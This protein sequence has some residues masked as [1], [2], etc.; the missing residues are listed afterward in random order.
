MWK[1]AIAA[2]KIIY[3]ELLFYVILNI[4]VFLQRVYYAVYCC[5]LVN[6]ILLFSMKSFS[7]LIGQDLRMS[8]HFVLDQ[9]P[10]QH[11]HTESSNTKK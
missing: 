7:F 3:K 1:N 5:Y 9:Y 11:N 10:L 4:D 6:T 8:L 2:G